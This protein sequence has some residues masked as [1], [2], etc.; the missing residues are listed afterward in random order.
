M[1]GAIDL[2]TTVT[3]VDPAHW[4]SERH[5]ASDTYR[6]QIEAADVLLANRGD[7]SSPEATERFLREAAELFPP[8]RVVGSVEHAAVT[9]DTLDLVGDGATGADAT[10]PPVLGFVAI[11]PLERAL[12]DHGATF[13]TVGV[14]IEPTVIFNDRALADWIADTRLRCGVLRVKG[15]FRTAGQ[16]V[17]W[18][19]T[20]QEQ[21]L[22]ATSHR[23]DSRVE[24]VLE[25]G[26]S[27]YD[28]A[29]LET[30]LRA[31]TV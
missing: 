12:H 21:S 31:L 29:A 8:K 13:R 10:R 5:R 14:R 16:W 23:R 24:L 9:A 15:V 28:E 30:E 6:D 1:A 2:R 7:L 17:A 20:P 22:A 25:R 3:L 18:N 27:D 11:R 19:A 26:M 4:S